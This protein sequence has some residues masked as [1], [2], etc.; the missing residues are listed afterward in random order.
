MTYVIKILNYIVSYFASI[1]ISTGVL[2]IKYEN[3]Y[4]KRGNP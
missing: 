1:N 2:A 4:G 3:F